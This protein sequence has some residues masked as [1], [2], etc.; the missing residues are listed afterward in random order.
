MIQK[1]KNQYIIEGCS[2]NNNF[3]IIIKK[4]NLFDDNTINIQKSSKNFRPQI[5]SFIEL[6]LYYDIDF[7]TSVKLFNDV[8]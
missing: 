4:N 5:L 2:L 7:S 1:F 6:S 8:S 3:K